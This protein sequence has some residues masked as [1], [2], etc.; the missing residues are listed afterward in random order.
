MANSSIQDLKNVAR[1]IHISCSDQ[2]WY[3][4]N[5][6]KYIS[7]PRCYICSLELQLYLQEC[8]LCSRS[9][10]RSMTNHFLRTLASWYTRHHHNKNVSQM[11]NSIAS[12]QQEHLT[13]TKSVTNHT[14]QLMKLFTIPHVHETDSNKPRQITGDCNMQL[15]F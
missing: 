14:Q 3:A 9:I 11:A 4:I 10:S 7:P 8:Y 5:L 12:S 1:S 13:L 2:P 15:G 6:S